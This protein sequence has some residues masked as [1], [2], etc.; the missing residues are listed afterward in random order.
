MPP[1]PLSAT[2]ALATLLPGLAAHQAAPAGD[3]AAGAAVFD[4][5]RTSCQVVQNATGEVLARR[6]ARTGPNLYGVV[7]RTPGER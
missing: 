4:R 1:A 5:Q 7:G 2:L 3:V 6:S